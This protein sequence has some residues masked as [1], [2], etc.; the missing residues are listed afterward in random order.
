MITTHC[1][2]T[3]LPPL[4]IR[5]TVGD[6]SATGYKALQLSLRSAWNLFG[7]R[8]QHAVCVNTVP[9]RTVM[10]QVGKLRFPVEWVSTSISRTQVVS[11]PSFTSNGGGSCLETYSP[12]VFFLRSTNCR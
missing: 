12:F 8:A 6:V 10:D 9:V 3:E 7:A 2:R 1:N 11:R 5:W 4:G